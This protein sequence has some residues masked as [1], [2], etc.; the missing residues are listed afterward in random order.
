MS[1]AEVKG[2]VVA[3]D[4]HPQAENR[5]N[6]AKGILVLGQPDLDPRSIVELTHTA[7]TTERSNPACTRR[8]VLLDL[9][10]ASW[11]R[12]QTAC[13]KDKERSFKIKLAEQGGNWSLFSRREMNRET[14]F[15]Q[16]QLLTCQLAIDYRGLR[17]P[18][19]NC[20]L[21]YETIND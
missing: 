21:T 2:R 18:T 9:C 12:G 14:T 16:S 5:C 13:R 4:Q 8:G 6:N 10:S 19:Q 7:S 20:W 3:A 1:T 17:R 11:P 15:L